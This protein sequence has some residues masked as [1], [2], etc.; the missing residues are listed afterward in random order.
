MIQSSGVW[1]ENPKLI[2]KKLK[3]IT[4]RK[5]E[6]IK[7]PNHAPQAVARAVAGGRCLWRGLGKARP[8]DPGRRTDPPPG[9]LLGHS[10]PSGFM[11]ICKPRQNRKEG[12]EET[13]TTTGSSH[14]F[15]PWSRN[16]PSCPTSPGHWAGGRVAPTY[17]SVLTRTSP[18]TSASLLS[19]GG[20]PSARRTGR[21]AHRASRCP[22]F[23]WTA[24]ARTLWLSEVAFAG[25]SR[26]DLNVSVGGTRF[27]TRTHAHAHTHAYTRTHTHTQLYGGTAAVENLDRRIL[28]CVRGLITVCND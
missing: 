10:G 13:G 12:G 23:S 21:G 25:S 17:A 24:S 20:H 8:A 16:A 27:N 19:S 9:T 11:K 22:H 5:E 26:Q 2:I 18:C 28:L 14:W 1:P 15:L 4:K 6:S 3:S 7:K